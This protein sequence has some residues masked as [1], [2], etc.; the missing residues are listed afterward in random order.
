VA[1]DE[2]SA[3]QLAEA[4]RIAKELVKLRDAGAIKDAND[5]EARFYAHLVRDFAAT[6]PGPMSNT[7]DNVL[8]VQQ[9]ERSW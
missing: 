7:G 3:E 4:S 9:K 2:L 6:Y 1:T 5:P 8:K